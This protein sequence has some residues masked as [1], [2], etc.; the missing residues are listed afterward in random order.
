[1]MKYEKMQMLFE[2]TSTSPMTDDELY[3]EVMTSLSN[4]IL[5]IKYIV[6]NNNGMLSKCLENVHCFTMTVKYECSNN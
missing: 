5:K 1:M 2:P 6:D 4:L 3:A